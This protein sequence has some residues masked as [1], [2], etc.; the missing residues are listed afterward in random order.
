[1]KYKPEKIQDPRNAHE[2][3]KKKSDTQRHVGTMTQD[4]QDLRWHEVHTQFIY[5]KKNKAKIKEVRVSNT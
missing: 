3:K 2:K 1:M 4:P 5:F